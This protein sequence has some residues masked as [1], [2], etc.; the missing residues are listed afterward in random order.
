VL[1]FL[2]GLRGAA[3]TPVFI[4]DHCRRGPATTPAGF[5]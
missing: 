5:Q 1:L 4:D 3:I 2:L